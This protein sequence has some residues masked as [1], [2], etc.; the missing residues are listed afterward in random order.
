MEQKDCKNADAFMLYW[1]ACVEGPPY[2]TKIRGILKRM[3]SD[4]CGHRERIWNMRDGVVPFGTTCP[5]CGGALH[6]VDWKLDEFAPN[7]KLLHFQKFWTAMTLDRAREIATKL[8]TMAS[9]RGHKPP[10]FD[11]LV[12]SCFRNG[13]EPM[14]WVYTRDDM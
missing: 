3:R 7:H 9:K 14:L 11:D 13:E 10:N 6:H 2:Y 4:P 8:Q 5:S 1:Y 12:K